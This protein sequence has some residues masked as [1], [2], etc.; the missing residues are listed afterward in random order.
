MFGQDRRRDIDQVLFCVPWT[1]PNAR[2]I[3]M[4]K[5]KKKKIEKEPGQYPAILTE[6]S[7]QIKRLL[8][9]FTANYNGARVTGYPEGTR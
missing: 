5:K 4:P 1:E 9:G 7:W 2:S 8:C 3:N 6:Q